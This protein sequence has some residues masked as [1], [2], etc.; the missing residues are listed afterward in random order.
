MFNRILG[1]L[2][3]NSATY[4]E[5]ARDPH[6]TGQVALIVTLVALLAGFISAFTFATPGGENFGATEGVLF[7]LA[8]VIAALVAWG[9]SAFAA[10]VVASAL[11]GG[12]TTLGEMLRV[13]GLASAFNILGVHPL[14]G[15]AGWVLLIIASAMGIHHVVAFGA[16]RAIATAVIAGALRFIIAY[17]LLGIILVILIW[18]WAL[19]AR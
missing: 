14:L 6:A 1:A 9:A 2:S 16:R 18:A 11:L 7:A 4:Q 19:T 17:L 10:T 12:K 5:V 8:N 13:T 3:F 15:I